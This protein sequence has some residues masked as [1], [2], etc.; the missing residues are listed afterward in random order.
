VIWSLV[1]GFFLKAG[2]T[3]KIKTPQKRSGYRG[4]FAYPLDM[5]EVSDYFRPIVLEPERVI[6]KKSLRHAETWGS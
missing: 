2:T 4:Q 6:A 3:E 5:W 1:R